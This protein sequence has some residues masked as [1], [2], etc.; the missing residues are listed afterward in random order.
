V[1]SG[2]TVLDLTQKENG[3][4][5]SVTRWELSADRKSLTATATALRPNGEV[6]AQYPASRVSGSNDFAGQ[7]RDTGYLQRHADLILRLDGQTLHI[8][9][10]NARQ[11]IDAPLSGADAEVKGPHNAKG[12][13]YAARI[14]GRRE[15]LFLTKSDGKVLTQDSMELSND[16]RVIT[17]SWWNPDKPAQRGT[18]VYEK[19]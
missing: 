2:T 15:F 5:T 12:L 9:Y 17:Y 16:G 13:T 14:V 1:K 11:S 6:T 7:W 4:K 18:F 10:P 19:N 3:V 8:G